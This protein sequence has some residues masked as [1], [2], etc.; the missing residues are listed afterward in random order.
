MQIKCSHNKLLSGYR[1]ECPDFNQPGGKTHPNLAQGEERGVLDTATAASLSGTGS[2][3]D[4]F[5]SP[6][7]IWNIALPCR[8]ALTSHWSEVQIIKGREILIWGNDRESQTYPAGLREN[9]RWDRRALCKHRKRA[10]FRRRKEL[11]R[12]FHRRIS[13]SNG[14]KGEVAPSSPS[15][16]KQI[17]S[18]WI[19]GVCALRIQGETWQ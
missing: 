2:S 14:K 18:L 17:Y 15:L 4:V 7:G 9:K 8:K 3:N 1:R 19:T 16:Q 11:F 12:D 5:T 13:S 10:A 6:D